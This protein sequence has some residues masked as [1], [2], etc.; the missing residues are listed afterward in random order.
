M[1]AKTVAEPRITTESE[2]W[3]QIGPMVR[4]D[5]EGEGK[6]FQERTSSTFDGLLDKYLGC[7]GQ[8]G[9]PAVL[10]EY[11]QWWVAEVEL[12][13]RRLYEI[14]DEART[15]EGIAKSEAFERVVFLTGLSQLTR[16]AQQ[17]G[18][19]TV[20]S[21]GNLYNENPEPYV[22]ELRRAFAALNAKWGQAS[23]EWEQDHQ[24]YLVGGLGRPSEGVVCGCTNCSVLGYSLARFPIR[25]FQ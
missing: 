3:Q 20:W 18:E 10:K 4:P 11:I 15:R 2:I 25:V 16:A 12:L 22:K 1:A 5:V 23:G 14:Y 21:I 7:A 19:K 13:G 6:R 24:V 17:D 9:Y 8:Y